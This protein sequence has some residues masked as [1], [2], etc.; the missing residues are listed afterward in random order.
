[1]YLAT[2]TDDNAVQ[3]RKVVY[4]DAN[5]IADEVTKLID[6]NTQ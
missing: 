5:R 1:V 6:D 2:S 3:L 4:D